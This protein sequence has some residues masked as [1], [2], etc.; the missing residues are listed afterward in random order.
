M[1]GAARSSARHADLRPIRARC[2]G[3]MPRD[4]GREPGRLGSGH[5]RLQLRAAAGRDRALHCADLFRQRT[6]RKR[7]A[8]QPRARFSRS[9]PSRSCWCSS[10][11]DISRSAGRCCANCARSDSCWRGSSRRSKCLASSTPLPVMIGVAVALRVLLSAEGPRP[12]PGLRLRLPHSLCDRAQPRPLA[13]IGLLTSV[14]RISRRLLSWVPRK[15]F[16][17]ASPCGSRPGATRC[18]AAIRW[19]IRF[20]PWHRAVRSG[21]GPGLGETDVIPA[22]YTD[23]IVSVLG[24]EWGFLGLAV[25]LPDLW[26]AD[27][28]GTAHRAPRPH[29]LCILPRT[30]TRHC[31]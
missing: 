16:T 26:R 11:R 4:A 2:R 20:G 10:S 28:A 22:G 31:C 21:T 18:A 14:R 25:R 8:R 6:R 3:R 19:R 13:V 29:G 5:G 12:G 30:G 24:E 9:K 7:C 15:P 1:V 27:L 17:I 23:L